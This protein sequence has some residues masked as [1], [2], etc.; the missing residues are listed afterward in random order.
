M[1]HVRRK[2]IA[3]RGPG[4]RVRKGRKMFKVVIVDDEIYIA[5]LIEQL[6]DWDRLNMSIIGKA[7][8]GFAALDMISNLNPDIAIVDVKMPGY[9]GITLIQKC[10]EK[11]LDVKFIVISGD[12]NF[13]YAQSAIK[14]N[15]EDYLLKPIEKDD[16]EGILEKLKA[17]LEAEQ[18]NQMRLSLMDSELLIRQNKIR[19]NFISEVI[20]EKPGVFTGSL[21]EIDRTC[22]V[23]FQPGEFL[24]AVLKFDFGEKN[25][26]RIFLDQ[27]L[28]KS[29]EAIS[30]EML[31]RCHDLLYQPAGTGIV[32]LLNYDGKKVPACRA[33]FSKAFSNLKEELQ[34]FK[35]VYITLCFGSRMN[36]FA[37]LPASLQD[38]R[39]AVKSRVALGMNKIISGPDL[40][41]NCRNFGSA[42]VLSEAVC[43]NLK[44]AILNFEN[45]ETAALVHSAF[46][47][48]A[49]GVTDDPLW[50]FTFCDQVFSLFFSCIEEFR[51][52]DA[53][54]S[55]LHARLNES[56]D[57]C[58][59]GEELI[60]A[61]LKFMKDTVGSYVADSNS[62][63]NP[64]VRIAKKYISEHYKEEIS[65]ASVSG[66]VNLNPVYFS[67][68]FKKET[69]LTFTSYTNQYRIKVAKDLL[70]N[71]Q[72]NIS[73]VALLSGF[74]EPRYFS[75]IFQKIV[76]IT[77][78]D[79]KCRH[80]SQSGADSLL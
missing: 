29:A 62:G 3:M 47:E 37:G 70:G 52:Q 53:D 72:Y 46:R 50:T 11:G 17:K 22:Y 73:E 51:P 63:E 23:R 65:L 9:D 2:A 60:E 4:R 28:Q 6:I 25:F 56:L 33:A 10:R 26:S 55:F 61:L 71:A 49:A 20:Q 34:K 57:T 68:I 44:T 41:K 42:V 30:R 13:E 8:N 21:E 78:T 19:S 24:A 14:Y 32:F 59:S 16:L 43:K 64:S 36:S 7:E 76:G 45:E 66:V 48:T 75:K 69:G 39:L 67:Y 79:Y 27:M 40:K 18:M 54:R 58:V 38:A 1:H 5:A 35:N 80:F 15:V 31:P 12:K 74:H 77:P